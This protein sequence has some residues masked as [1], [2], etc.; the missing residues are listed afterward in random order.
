MEF[1]THTKSPGWLPLKKIF[2]DSGPEFLA[3]HKARTYSEKHL[4]G[5][6]MW[7]WLCEIGRVS[8]ELKTYGEEIHFRP[9]KG[10]DGHPL[11]RIVFKATLRNTAEFDALFVGKRIGPT[12]RYARL[13]AAG[14]VPASPVAF[15]REPAE[16]PTRDLPPPSRTNAYTAIREWIVHA[17]GREW[18]YVYTLK[19]ELDNFANSGIEP[20][21]KIGQTR[22]HYAVRIAGQLGR[23]A[24][25]SPPV[26]LAAYRV[27]DAQQVESALHRVLK[28]QGRHVSDAPGIEWFEIAPEPLHELICMVVGVSMSELDA[29]HGQ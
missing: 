1:N 11:W 3:E 8:S 16:P 29:Q 10:K 17:E 15:V 18:L 7:R 20:L 13:A 28:I 5:A 6:D 27:R 4:I 21:L 2:I 24:A 22:Q 14:V 25:H 19:R 12:P 23:T 26:C 9:N